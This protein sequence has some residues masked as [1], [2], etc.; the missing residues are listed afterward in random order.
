MSV[1][2]AICLDWDPFGEDRVSNE[3]KHKAEVSGV[4][5]SDVWGTAMGVMST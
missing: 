4:R 3:G 2:G 1:I 5:E